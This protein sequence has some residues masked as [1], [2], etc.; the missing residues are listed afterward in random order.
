MRGVTRED[1]EVGR[2]CCRVKMEERPQKKLRV[3]EKGG[4]G[5]GGGELS[6]RILSR[7]K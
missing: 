3:E 1:K 5:G 4:G 2:W 6:G 7:T